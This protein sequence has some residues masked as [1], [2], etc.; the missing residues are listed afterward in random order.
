MQ[1]RYAQRIR[2]KNRPD[3]YYGNPKV[4]DT[5]QG[6]RSAGSKLQYLELLHETIEVL[7][8]SEEKLRTL[9]ID[10]NYIALQSFSQSMITL[11]GNI[12]AEEMTSMFKEIMMYLSTNKTKSHLTEYILLYQKNHQ[13]LK[14]EIAFFETHITNTSLS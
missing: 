7:E 13:H 11:Y 12:H 8:G 9:I 10:G 5:I 14:D 6:I 4:L 1:A 2:E 3:T